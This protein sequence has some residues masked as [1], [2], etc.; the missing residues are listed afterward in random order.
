MASPSPRRI[1]RKQS[2]T[3]V[4][5]LATIMP[6]ATVAA[7]AATIA[8]ALLLVLIT[9]PG[10][11]FSPVSALAPAASPARAVT[12]PATAAAAAPAATSA[13]LK[14]AKHEPVRVNFTDCGAKNIKEV[15][16]W[17]CPGDGTVCNIN[18]GTNITVEADFIAKQEASSLSE[19]IKGIIRGRE[20]QFPEQRADP[21]KSTISPGCPIKI[22]KHYQY[23]AQFEVKAHYPAIPVKV[24]YALANGNG[25]VIACVQISAR[26]VDPSPVRSS[27]TKPKKKTAAR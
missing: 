22:G 2:P 12:S 25:D 1:N 14:S 10:Q 16:I 5:Q 6:T 26:I 24:R 8:T 3:V 11:L 7:A 13:A 27:R 4:G 15:R 9:S 23:K 17:P 18:L 20:L 19:I 21:C